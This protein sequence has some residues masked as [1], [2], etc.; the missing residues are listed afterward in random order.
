M[1][2]RPSGGP[3]S[4]MLTQFFLKSARIPA[5]NRLARQKNLLQSAI[6]PVLW[7]SSSTLD[8]GRQ[9]LK[10]RSR[11][12]KINFRTCIHNLKRPS[13]RFFCRPAALKNLEI[14]KGFPRFFALRG[15]KIP[16]SP[17]IFAY[18]Y[19]FLKNT[20]FPPLV[21]RGL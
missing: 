14:H 21:S 17:G 13:E 2:I 11:C 3:F 18:E 15:G 8:F 12:D 10:F 9:R 1:S 20:W 4:T 16:R 6:P 19:R 5:S 7:E